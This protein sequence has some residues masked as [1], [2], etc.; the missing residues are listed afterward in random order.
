MTT[1]SR[2][3]PEALRAEHWLLFPSIPK[4]DDAPSQWIQRTIS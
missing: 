1:M 4:R 2:E 3:K